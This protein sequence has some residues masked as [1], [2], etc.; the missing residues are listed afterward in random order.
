MRVWYDI[1]IKEGKRTMKSIPVQNLRSNKLFNSQKKR[2]ENK[3]DLDSRE[4]EEQLIKGD[5]ITHNRKQHRSGKGGDKSK[6][7]KGRH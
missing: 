3:D 4:G 2:P 6:D 7:Q 5:D 1:L